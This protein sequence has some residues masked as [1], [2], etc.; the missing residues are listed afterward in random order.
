MERGR[1]ILGTLPGRWSWNGTVILQTF[2]LPFQFVFTLRPSVS[3]SFS[4]FIQSGSQSQS[5]LIHWFV[6]S[7]IHSFI[8]SVSQLSFSHSVSQSAFRNS[9]SQSVNPDSHLLN[10]SFI[11]SVFLIYKFFQSI[12]QS[13]GHSFSQSVSQSL[14]SFGQSVNRSDFF[15]LSLSLPLCFCQFLCLSHFHSL[16]V[17]S[18]RSLQ[19]IQIDSL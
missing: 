1:G 3:Q 12:S 13:A 7:F 4:H 11:Q 19:G 18:Y 17:C 6:H 15:R 8:E 5:F 9:V 2:N 10:H 14:H 16:D